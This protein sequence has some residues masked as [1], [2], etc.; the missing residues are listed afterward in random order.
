[1]S[2]EIKENHSLKNQYNY[3]PTCASTSKEQKAEI[4]EVEVHSGISFKETSMQLQPI[5][6]FLD[7]LWGK[8]GE[9]RGV[10]QTK[11]LVNDSN[12]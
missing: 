6:L 2:Y 12:Y 8:K 7:C 11:S 4:K 10:G 1:M 3:S 9:N 5:V